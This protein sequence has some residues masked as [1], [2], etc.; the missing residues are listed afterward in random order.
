MKT[1]RR[2][3]ARRDGNTAVNPDQNRRDFLRDSALLLAALGAPSA[4]VFAGQA[5]ANIEVIDMS[6]RLIDAA[7][8]EGTLT[9]RY[10]SPVDE[11]T[12]MA[13]AFTAKFGIKCQL[14]RKV[15][16]LATQQFAQETRAGRHLMD[17]NYTADPAGTRDLADDDMYLR[18]TLADLDKKLDKGSYLPGLGYSPKWTDIVI[19]YNPEHIPTPRRASNSRPGR[20]CSTRP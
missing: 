15:G 20:V 16:G 18:Y 4:E 19:S 8:K 9:I 10:S 2:N 11:M 17:V 1:D 7:K 14:N 12:L 3:Q 6:Q 5:P 13:D